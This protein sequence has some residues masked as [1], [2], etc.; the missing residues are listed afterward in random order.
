MSENLQFQTR[1]LV[2]TSLLVKK[3]TYTIKQITKELCL[4]F[5][6][7]E[8]VG[9]TF[10]ELSSCMISFLTIVKFSQGIND[11]TVVVLYNSTAN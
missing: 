3:K 10:D 1:S 11:L 8:A 5:A 7:K 9:W 2:I 6:L 4:E